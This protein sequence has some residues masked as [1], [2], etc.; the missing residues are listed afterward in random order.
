MI[1]VLPAAH[2]KTWLEIMTPV[3]IIHLDVIL[4]TLDATHTRHMDETILTIQGVYSNTLEAVLTTRLGAMIL[5]TTLD[6]THT[7][8]TDEATLTTTLDMA[9]PTCPGVIPTILL[10]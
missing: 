6:A 8:R 10:V 4:T 7:C 3:A 2:T 5:T 1:M 9:L